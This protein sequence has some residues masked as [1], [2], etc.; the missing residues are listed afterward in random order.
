MDINDI[1]S[2]AGVVFN[3][4]DPRFE[5]VVDNHVIGR[6]K[7]MLETNK[8]NKYLRYFYVDIT[9]L[10]NNCFFVQKGKEILDSNSMK[11]EQ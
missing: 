3:K 10:A 6:K 4:Q 7:V 5:S 11:T 1:K 8:S 9:N 2:T